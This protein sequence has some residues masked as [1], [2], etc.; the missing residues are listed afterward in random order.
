MQQNHQIK[1]QHLD[2]KKAISKTDMSGGGNDRGGRGRRGGRAGGGGGWSRSD[3][4]GNQGWIC[5]CHCQA[6]SLT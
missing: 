4:W 6:L 5:R 1:D 3:Q 2:V